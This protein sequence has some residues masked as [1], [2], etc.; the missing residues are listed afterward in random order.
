MGVVILPLANQLSLVIVCFAAAAAAINAA[1]VAVTIC[2]V[3]AIVVTA[4]IVVVVAYI[5]TCIVIVIL[6][7]FLFLLFCIPDCRVSLSDSRLTPRFSFHESIA[8]LSAS[9]QSRDSVAIHLRP[10]VAT[11]QVALLHGVHSRVE[12]RGSE[13]LGVIKRKRVHDHGASAIWPCVHCPAT[14]FSRVVFEVGPVQIDN[15]LVVNGAAVQTLVAAQMCV[16]QA[17]A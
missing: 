16:D 7:L 15:A 17:D 6:L 2:A 4:T 8:R 12:H 14:H 13:Q 3:T 1:V 10:R 9:H 5:V 11:T